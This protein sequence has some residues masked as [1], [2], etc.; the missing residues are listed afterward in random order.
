VKILVTPTSFK[1]DSDSPAMRT[2]KSF[3]DELVFNP[4]GRPLGEDELADLLTGCDGMI[5]GVD[6]LSEKAIMSA[7]RLKV[8]S[9][10]GVGYD[11][12]DIAAARKKG[13]AVTNTPGANS[14]AVAEL[15][16][17]LMLSLARRIPMLDRKTKA[18]EWA[19]YT[20]TELG[21]KTLGILGLGAVGRLVAK[22]AVGFAMHV[23][24]YD[25]YMDAAYAEQNG[26][27]AV[28]LEE[29]IASS[30]F[31]SL[32]LPLKNDTRHL[33]DTKSISR[34]KDG[35][36]IINTARG[37]IIDEEAVLA[38]LE[39][40]KIGGLGLDAYEQEPPERSKLFEMDNV[41]MTPHAAAHT[42]E[43]T[44]N[45]ANASVANLIAVLSGQECSAIVNK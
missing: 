12:V 24:A 29:V 11:R 40:G 1:P 27:G 17:G 25:P 36:V 14:K 10:Y 21:G 35:A 41:V 31:I 15:A 39:A 30:D 7:D 22:Q 6:F 23:V 20:G 33:I 16:F 38:A 4:Y 43:A 37:G 44:E 34:M 26:I 9:R 32:H 45:M 18:S 19:Q 42:R 13:I 5:A 3:A 2:L 28:S 8:I